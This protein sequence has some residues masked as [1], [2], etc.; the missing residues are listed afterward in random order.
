MVKILIATDEKY[1]D[2]YETDRED[3]ADGCIE[4]SEEEAAQWR[5]AEEVIDRFDPIIKERLEARCGLC[6]GTGK[7]DK[8]VCEVC[9]GSG[10]AP[11][12]D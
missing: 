4:M 9:F 7:Y 3:R 1:P 11:H 8:H 2:Y 12:N 10:N 6:R 5:A